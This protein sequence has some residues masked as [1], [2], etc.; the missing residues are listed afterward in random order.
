MS[1]GPS[2]TKPTNLSPLTIEFTICTN[3]PDVAAHLL[4]ELLHWKVHMLG[5]PYPVR[6]FDPSWFPM[7]VNEIFHSIFF[8]EFIACGFSPASF[9]FECEDETDKWIEDA[10][11]NLSDP[12]KVSDERWQTTCKYLSYLIAGETTTLDVADKFRVQ[13]IGLMPDIE[14]AFDFVK[15][16]LRRKEFHD[17]AHFAN[18]FT[19]LG[20]RVRPPYV[21][22]GMVKKTPNGVEIA[23][24]N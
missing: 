8:A 19:E 16:W 1:G 9:L 20:N 23:T 17:P 2:S 22:F 24:D 7:I 15:D 14:P 5:F 12:N 6:F 21:K 3:V 13:A 4:H 10:R 11:T 18:S